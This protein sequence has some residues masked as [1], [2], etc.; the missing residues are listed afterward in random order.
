MWYITRI[1]IPFGLLIVAQDLL[2]AYATG[3][4]GIPASGFPWPLLILAAGLLAG[5][6]S[7]RARSGLMVG[8]TIGLLGVLGS[9]LQIRL[10][11][12]AYPYFQSSGEWFRIFFSLATGWVPIGAILGGGA[13]RLGAELRRRRTLQRGAR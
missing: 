6:R 13:A 9:S 4:G 12:A 5:W 7:G 10:L 3:G 2:M 1:A 11:P 8:A